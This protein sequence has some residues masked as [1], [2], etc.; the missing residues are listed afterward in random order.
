MSVLETAII[1]DNETLVEKNFGNSDKNNNKEVHTNILKAVEILAD[2]L[3]FEDVESFSI[4]NNQ[5]IVLSRKINFQDNPDNVL[6]L[7]ICT[8]IQKDTNKKK[9]L[10][11]MNEA[12]D[13]FLQRFHIL[14]IF[15][16]KKEIFGNFQENLNY[17]FAKISE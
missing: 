16:K 3:F 13:Q 9:V 11:C 4:G 10:K 17:I 14:H 1:Y 8:L 15:L 5:L 6:I 7:K 12:I 2:T